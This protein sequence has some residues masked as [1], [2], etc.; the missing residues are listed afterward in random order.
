MNKMMSILGNKLKKTIIHVEIYDKNLCKNIF[1]CCN[2]SESGIAIIGNNSFEIGDE[3]FI[4]IREKIKIAGSI[5]WVKNRKCG[6]KFYKKVN[7]I[8]TFGSNF[9]I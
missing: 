4:F 7:L 2:I 9:D 5:V 6:V 1:S 8:S 3:V